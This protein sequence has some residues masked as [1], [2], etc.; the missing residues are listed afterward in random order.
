MPEQKVHHKITWEKAVTRRSKLPLPAIAVLRAAADYANGDGDRV[1]PGL[2]LLA[3]GLGISKNT[4]SKW[5]RAGEDAG[6]LFKLS[7]GYAVNGVEVAN[8][9][10]LTIPEWVD[11]TGLNDKARVSE[12]PPLDGGRSNDRVSADAS[13][14]AIAGGRS[15]DRV[16]TFQRSREHVPAGVGSRNTEEP[17]GTHQEHREIPSLGIFT[18]PSEVAEREPSVWDLVEPFTP[19]TPALP[20]M[21]KPEPVA[22]PWAGL[23]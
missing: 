20:V 19:A 7:E 10:R 2:R 9:Y 17:K 15:N 14:P 8:E 12:G 3:E 11:V 6:W 23:E 1:R 18:R 16:N 22:D 13:V 21:V 5:M 4:A